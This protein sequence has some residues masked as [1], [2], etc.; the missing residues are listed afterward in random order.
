VQINANIPDL[1][2]AKQDIFGNLDSSLQAIQNR[3]DEIRRGS[4]EAIQRRDLLISQGAQ[5]RLEAESLQAELDELTIGRDELLDDEDL[6]LEDNI[7]AY[8]Q[9]IAGLLETANKADDMAKIVTWQQSVKDDYLRALNSS[10]IA[11][12]RRLQTRI[13]DNYTSKITG[14]LHNPADPVVSEMLNKEF[15]PEKNFELNSLQNYIQ[16]LTV[17]QASY[18]S[19]IAL[20]KA[21]TDAI[22]IINSQTNADIAR[23]TDPA[24]KAKYKA[25]AKVQIDTINA[26]SPTIST[27]SDYSGIY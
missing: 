12:I 3:L 25:D 14:E 4:I 9:E 17:T 10:E 6:E 18:S 20:E 8:Q 16:Q 26:F 21:K 13:I 27:P 1:K 7:R 15:I 23:T 2:V 22:G 19:K 5:A 11:E 24:L